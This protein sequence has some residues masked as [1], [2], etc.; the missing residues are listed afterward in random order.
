MVVGTI[1]ESQHKAARAVGIA[2]WSRMQPRSLLTGARSFAL[3]IFPNLADILGPW[4][5][6]PLLIFESATAL[7]LLLKGLRP[8]GVRVD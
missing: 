7:W 5:Y 6:V 8:S 2:T 4:C 3:I 1:H